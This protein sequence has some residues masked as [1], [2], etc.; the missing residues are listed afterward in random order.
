MEAKELRELLDRVKKPW[1]LQDPGAWM[2]KAIVDDNGTELLVAASERLNE[3]TL[4]QLAPDLARRVLELE[5]LQDGLRKAG[6]HL[7]AVYDHYMGREACGD[8]TC[9]CGNCGLCEMRVSTSA[10]IDAAAKLLKP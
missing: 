6:E 8:F 10:A 1:K 7:Q 3:I 4:A 5:Q 2:M 9:N